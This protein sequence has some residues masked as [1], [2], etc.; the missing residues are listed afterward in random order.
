MF[1]DAAELFVAELLR[2]FAASSGAAE[3]ALGMRKVPSQSAAS[4]V[5]SHN[6]CKTVKLSGEGEN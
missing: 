5:V 2:H 6:L 3:G 4:S 1:E